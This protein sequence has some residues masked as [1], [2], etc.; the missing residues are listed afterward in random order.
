MLVLG[1]I[2]D[3]QYLRL[4]RA[5]A[6]RFEFVRAREWGHVLDA[7]RRLPVELAVIDPL[8]GGEP[9]GQEVERLRLLF[10]SLP[11]ILYTTLT[12][13]L[14]TVLLSLG[15]RGIKQVIFARFDDHRSE[16]H[17]SELQSHVN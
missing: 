4:R 9:R 6:E 2:P 1:A 11:L 7:I 17:T 8:L 13:E 12:P 10:P 5:T 16:E 3:V 15:Q 14:A